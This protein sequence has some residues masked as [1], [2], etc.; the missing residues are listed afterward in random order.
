MKVKD[1]LKQIRHDDIVAA[2]RHAELKTSG[3]IRVFISHKKTEDAVAAGQTAFLRM[4][5]AK[6]RH[7]N[8]VLIFVAPKAHKF[9]VI[10]DEAV[11]QKCGDVFWQALTAEMSGYFKR[12]EFTQG[13]LHGVQKAGE[14]LAAHFPPHP[15][16]KNQGP[17]PVEQD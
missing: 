4:G 11:H 1:F 3:E 2:I 12:S 10:G 8:G 9:A 16:D 5:M 13:I 15:G 6:T 14:L 7:R 17:D